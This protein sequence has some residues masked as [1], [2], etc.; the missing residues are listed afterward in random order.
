MREELGWIQLDW[1]PVRRAMSSL[2]QPIPTARPVGDWKARSAGNKDKKI[3]VI[4]GETEIDGIFETFPFI[5][6]E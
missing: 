5:G 3:T 2:T 1:I 4:A 6:C